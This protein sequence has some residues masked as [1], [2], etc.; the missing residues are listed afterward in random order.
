MKP[1]Q[2]SAEKA[3]REWQRFHAANP[4]VYHLFKRYALQ[5]IR[6]GETRIGGRLIWERIRW[7]TYVRLRLRTEGKRP[8]MNDHLVPFYIRLFVLENPQHREK[9]ALRAALADWY[10]NSEPAS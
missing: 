8:R 10:F 3:Y 6:S 1:T 4:V 9:F 5:L 7:E 2:A